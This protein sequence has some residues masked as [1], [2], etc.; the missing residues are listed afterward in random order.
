MSPFAYRIT[1][2][3]VPLVITTVTVAQQRQLSVQKTPKFL[4]CLQQ[5]LLLKP[6]AG[7][8][9]SVTR[10]ASRV[11]PV[12]GDVKLCRPHVVREIPGVLTVRKG[13]SDPCRVGE[14]VQQ[15]QG[16]R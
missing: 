12:L 9:Q 1:C 14:K 10:E 2:R 4:A 16:R 11:Q 13:E 7:L 6:P 3:F 5:E 8:L 15:T